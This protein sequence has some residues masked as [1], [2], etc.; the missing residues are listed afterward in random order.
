MLL[1]AERGARLLEQAGLK[2]IFVTLD[3]QI[4]QIGGVSD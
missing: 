3:L 4:T 2:G 1:G